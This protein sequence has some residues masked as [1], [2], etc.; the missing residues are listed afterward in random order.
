MTALESWLTQ[1]TRG[2]SKDSAAQV[3][4]EIQEHFEA[5][6]ELAMSRGAAAEE[7]E[8]RALA[9]LG[10]ARAANGQ[11]RRVLLTAEEAR[12]LRTGNWE[13]RAVCSRSWLK[14]LP[15]VALG[16]ASVAY[17]AGTV[18]VARV[19]FVLG[20]GM[21]LMFTAPL[22]P[23]YTPSRGRVFRVVKWAVLGGA[24]LVAFGPETRK[25]SWLLLSCLWPLIWIEWTRM[26]IRRKLR[27][28]EWP[29]QLY[30]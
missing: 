26:S 9:A 28:E 13:A 22:L 7:A 12:M 3:R 5:A 16:A 2:L 21:G 15:A 25:F 18:D 8:R 1:A 27:V 24:F 19:L 20:M 29:K 17:Y 14:W 30:L 23:V 4:V 6:R 10:D 11:Y